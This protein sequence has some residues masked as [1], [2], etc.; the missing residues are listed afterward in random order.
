MFAS[1]FGQLQGKKD[2]D[3]RNVEEEERPGFD[4]IYMR[5]LITDNLNSIYY[6]KYK[7]FMKIALTLIT[8]LL[9]LSLYFSIVIALFIIPNLLEVY[10]KDFPFV[11][12]DFVKV[13]ASGLANVLLYIIFNGT[14]YSSFSTV[15]TNFENHK[16]F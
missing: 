11:Q 2:D 13:A 7:R 16:S 14:I 9:M 8:C 3:D 12:N 1:Q 4:G 10:G 5:S 15:L 6:P